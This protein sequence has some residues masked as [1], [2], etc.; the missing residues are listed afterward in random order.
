MKQVVLTKIA[1]ILFLFLA[2]SS[3]A[4][5]TE[6]D[7]EKTS[8]EDLFYTARGLTQDH[9]YEQAIPI[10]EYL[11]KK[12]QNN[13]HLNYQ[14]GYCYNELNKF[15]KAYTP[16]DIAQK[17]TDKKY[18][19]QDP[20]EDNAPLE[21]L[22][23][24][25]EI[26]HLKGEIEKAQIA[27]NTFKEKTDN[28]HILIEKA[29]LH[30]IQCKNADSL[31]NNATA[32]VI[33]NL[34]A[35]INSEYAEYSPI[36]TLDGSSLFF[37]SR[38]LR[39]DDS[40]IKD[41]S[42]Q[43]GKY[44]EDIY[45]SKVL[46]NGSWGTPELVD[47]SRTDRNEASV[48]TSSSGQQIFVY[49]DDEGDGNIYV[50]DLFDTVFTEIQFFDGNLNTESW[51]SHACISP[52]GNTIFFVSDREGGYGGRDIYRIKK[53]PTG[54]WSLA[55]NLGPKINTKYDEEAP[56]IGA[57]GKTMY[58]ASNGTLSMGGFDL[59]SSQFDDEV[60]SWTTPKNMGYPLN[61]FGDDIFYTTSADGFTGYFASQRSDSK[62]DKDIYI[63][64]SPTSLISN[65][66]IMK[67]NIL[68][69]DGS[70]IPKG[71]KIYVEN[72]GTSQKR[73]YSPR[74]EDGGY[75]FD[76]KPCETFNIN[77]TLDGKSFYETTI[78][79]P[80]N[81]SYQEINRVLSINPLT[82]KATDKGYDLAYKSLIGKRW[83]LNKLGF[84]EE[85]IG[86][87]VLIYDEND[88]MLYEELVNKKGQFPY[89]TLDD[90]NTY[91]M[92]VMSDEDKLCDSIVIE[93]VDENG[94]VY[95]SIQKDENCDFVYSFETIAP[96]EKEFIKYFGYNNYEVNETK[97]LNQFIKTL[98]LL[99]S[100]NESVE[101][102]IV[103]SA[104]KVPTRKFTSNEV[105][106]AK[107]LQN[108]IVLLKTLCK[109][110]N[111]DFTKIKLQKKS[112]VQG[113]KYKNDAGEN[114]EKYQDYQY[115]S[116]KIQ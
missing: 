112:V 70:L 102:E 74:R 16:L 101:V 37:T 109:D 42:P 24:F 8:Y 21:A 5:P 96:E 18:N 33:K 59:I 100:Q 9:F 43:D 107:R 89:R 60:S 15:N 50:S 10:W 7:F 62:G 105:L 13:P 54:D 113:P 99:T 44:F 49:Q 32:Y 27:F 73:T 12:D 98:S 19:P 64:Q 106:A 20:K 29:D 46:P 90:Q 115:I 11:V 28:K 68:M 79:V 25:G 39:S 40:N 66:A 97:S 103:S 71:I 47:F 92:K 17:A 38:R 63:A 91:I 26:L 61:S 30:I 14:L 41:V 3:F 87:K 6:E 108:G 52:D 23:H 77:Y 58:Y 75:V 111:I 94:K 72:A 2:T 53:L 116:F 56:F 86:T 110:N 69:E 51:E 31:I 80:C 82:M 36:V 55:Q 93:L 35:P 4:Q 48:S 95:E 1:T 45:R 78:D 67:G 81:S 57:D 22:F 76:L 83:Q 84:N 34:H 85:Y 104:S 88:I 114:R 65:V